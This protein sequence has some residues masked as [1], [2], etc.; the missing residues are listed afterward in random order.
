MKQCPKCKIELK[1]KE[2]GETTIDEC[3]KCKG[4]WFDEDELRK[5][6]DFTDPDLNWLDFEIWKHEDQFKQK[7]SSLICP[8][9]KTNTKAINYGDTSIEVDYCPD[10]KGIWL[11]KGEF[12]KIIEALEEEVLS[13]SFS[14][15][16]S[17]TL[18]EAKEIISGPENF[19]SEWKD[20]A[21]ILRMMQYRF[22][23]ENPKLAEKL[24]SA[25]QINPIK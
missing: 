6:K 16:F 8:N 17:A 13:K 12:K 5:V 1:P 3:L 18:R 4:V 14:N 7:E 2:I 21:T 23:T 15:Y 25:Q 19:I 9:C 11:D 22:L 10:C 24:N 20:F